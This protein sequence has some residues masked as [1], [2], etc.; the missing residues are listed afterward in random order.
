[1]SLGTRKTSVQEY[2]NTPTTSV[3]MDKQ[4]GFTET[5]EKLKKKNLK[6]A[7]KL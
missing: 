4:D 3:V 7:W 2:V 6:L 5:I 1:M